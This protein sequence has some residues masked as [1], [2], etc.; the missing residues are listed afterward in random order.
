MSSQTKYLDTQAMA[1]MFVVVT[2]VKTKSHAGNEKPEMTG[3]LTHSLTIRFH[4]VGST[5]VAGSTVLVLSRNFFL[6]SV[7]SVGSVPAI[8]HLRRSSFTTSRHVFFGLP[9]AAVPSMRSVVTWLIHSELLLTCPN[10][11]SLLARISVSI[12]CMASF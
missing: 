10:H 5:D 9:R 4:V 1:K 8:P 11:R 6:H 3:L 12:G 7:R 2:R